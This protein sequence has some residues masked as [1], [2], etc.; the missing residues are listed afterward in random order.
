MAVAKTAETPPEFPRWAELRVHSGPVPDAAQIP[1]STRR[2]ED[3]KTAAVPLGARIAQLERELAQARQDLRAALVTTIRSQ[4][5]PGVAFSASELFQHR[6]VNPALA[7]AFCDA[8]IHSPRQ[9]GKRLRQLCGSG[10]ERIDA[11][12]HGAIWTC[13]P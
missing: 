5:G 4:I 1:S 6:L 10:L 9:L 12:K 13:S 2:P 3:G 7:A 11:D 8:G